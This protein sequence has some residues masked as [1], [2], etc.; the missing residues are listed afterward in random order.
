MMGI[1]EASVLSCRDNPERLRT[2]KAL[3]LRPEDQR[4]S[5]SNWQGSNGKPASQGQVPDDLAT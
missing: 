5:L 4:D 2:A 3:S 1:N